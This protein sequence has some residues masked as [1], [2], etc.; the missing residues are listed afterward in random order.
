MIKVGITGGI[1]SGKTTACKLF[2]KLGVPVYYADQRAKD[3]MTDDKGVRSEI[4]KLFGDNAYLP[5]GS[6]DR[7]YIA[8]IAFKDEHK[9]IALNEVVHPAVALDSESWNA[10]LAN[11]GFAYSI[12][13]AALL[14]ESGS[15]KLLDKLIVVSAPEEE[16]IKRV[17][18]RDATDE[19]SVRARIKAQLSEE[20]KIKIADY[21]IYN[22][23][24]IKLAEQVKAIHEQLMI[25]GNQN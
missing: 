16:R 12:K 10:I 5:D 6:L 25:L 13:E 1:G 21:V 8:S 9:L 7:A 11:K 20:E 19:A 22:T 4:V 23:D 14:I 2:E 18:L 3:I 15:Y 24:L 17:M